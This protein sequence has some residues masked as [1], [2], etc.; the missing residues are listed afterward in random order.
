[1]ETLSVFKKNDPKWKMEDPPISAI[2]PGAPLLLENHACIGFSHVSH[3]HCDGEG[4]QPNFPLEE[5]LFFLHPLCLLSL[6][7][8]IID[9]E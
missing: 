6:D 7:S 1:M 2:V 4:L 9:P 3:T 5:S 8:G